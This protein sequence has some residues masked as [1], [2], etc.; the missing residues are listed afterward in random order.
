MEWGALGFKL[1]WNAVGST[2]NISVFVITNDLTRAENAE[3]FAG[4]KDD[5]QWIQ[6]NCLPVYSVVYPGSPGLVS[7]LNVLSYTNTAA[8]VPVGRPFLVWLVRDGYST[9]GASASQLANR[10]IRLH[11]VQIIPPTAEIVVPA[12]VFTPYAPL[13]GV[14]SVVSIATS[15]V[16]ED[17]PALVESATFYRVYGSSAVTTPMVYTNGLWSAFVTNST[18]G[19]FPSW[20]Q[21][22]Y[23]G[24]DS[25]SSALSVKTNTTHVTPIPVYSARQN[26]TIVNITLTDI[27]YDTN[28]AITNCSINPPGLM[29][30]M[31][32]QF[33]ITNGL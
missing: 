13:L 11:E 2:N 29:P 25:L 32:R 4:V 6:T 19:V 1:A 22:I 12:P 7:E 21:T 5:P 30:I 15:S 28:G 8:V 33:G 26:P 20:V 31:Q 27:S 9:A 3:L 23:R 18:A 14:T 17:W 24:F 16:A 10:F